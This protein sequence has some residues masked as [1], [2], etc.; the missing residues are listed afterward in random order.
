MG[1]NRS[2]GGVGGISARVAIGSTRKTALSFVMHSWAESDPVSLLEK[3][4]SLPRPMWQ[5]AVRQGVLV[6]SRTAPKE[7]AIQLARLEQII[8][9]IEST[10]EV[11]F[12][13]RWAA[14]DPVAAMRWVYTNTSV[15]SF[16][17]MDM[18]RRVVESF[19]RVNPEEAMK[20]TLAED[21]YEEFDQ[22]HLQTLVIHTVAIQG[23]LKLAVE[24]LDRVPVSARFSCVLSI[25]DSLLR[26]E[27]S[28][29]A[30][31]L[32]AHVSEAKR[33]QF[34]VSLSMR[35]W[36]I[37]PDELFNQLASFPSAQIRA[38][39]AQAVLSRSERSGC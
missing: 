20:L 9:T 32:S 8:G 31:E 4:E 27:Q 13:G 30:M 6:L 26:T 12:V 23:K 36:D 3:V 11:T 21:I 14:V 29:Q 35:W 18:E 1:A 15:L 24:L 19:A 7:V 10:T 37:D 22:S 28:H 39:V 17:R 25:A 2:R 33:T 16:R 38:E 34:F 5:E